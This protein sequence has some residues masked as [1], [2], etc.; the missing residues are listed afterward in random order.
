MSN[1]IHVVDT[2]STPGARFKLFV[3][4]WVVSFNVLMWGPYL[5]FSIEAGSAVHMAIFWIAL[6]LSFILSFW[7]L[8]ITKPKPQVDPVSGKKVVNNHLRCPF[9]ESSN[10]G[11]REVTIDR[12]TENA[13]VGYMAF[14]KPG[15]VFGCAPDEVHKRL[16]CYDC[17]NEF[18]YS[19]ALVFEEYEAS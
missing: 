8:S 10:L 1:K 13:M 18:D 14:G 12:S 11:Q 6:V 15:L 19:E 4:S 2:N 9:C 5:L 7:I 16:I 17:A 3:K